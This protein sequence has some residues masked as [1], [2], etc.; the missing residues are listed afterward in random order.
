MRCTLCGQPVQGNRFGM[1]VICDCVIESHRKKGILP[2]AY[3]LV[4]SK[5]GDWQ[6]LYVNGLLKCEGHSFPLSDV[7]EALGLELVE[8]EIDMEEMGSLPELYKELIV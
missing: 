7:F 3:A 2:P 1:P 6:G 5:D 8:R 4:S